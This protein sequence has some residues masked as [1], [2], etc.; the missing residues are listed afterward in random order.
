[1]AQSVTFFALKD[2]Q[3]S[4]SGRSRPRRGHKRTNI[5]LVLARFRDA[6]D[7]KSR[8]RETHINVPIFYDFWGAEI[9]KKLEMFKCVTFSALKA[10]SKCE[11]CEILKIMISIQ[12]S[13]S[14]EHAFGQAK[15]TTSAIF[16]HF[17][18]FCIS[19]FKNT[20]D[21]YFSIGPD[22]KSNEP[23]PFFAKVSLAN[24]F[25]RGESNKDFH[26]REK[27]GGLIWLFV[28]TYGKKW[29]IDFQKYLK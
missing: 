10:W 22:E 18:N 1:M 17:F 24:R 13:R 14:R 6:R 12:I 9:T 23:S 29:R 15:H 4:I 19:F 7:R 8:K 3:K 2:N 27:G 21:H 11:I 25:Y 26:E 5:L 16:V 28:G 20:H